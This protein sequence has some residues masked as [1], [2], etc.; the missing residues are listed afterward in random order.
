MKMRIETRSHDG[1]MWWGYVIAMT[2]WWAGLLLR[3]GTL[4]PPLNSTTC[5]PESSTQQDALARSPN[6][7]ISIHQV[8]TEQHLRTV[9]PLVWR[10]QSWFLYPGNVSLNCKQFACQQQSLLAPFPSPSVTLFHNLKVNFCGIC[11][12]YKTANDSNWHNNLNKHW[13]AFR[14]SE[15]DDQVFMLEHLSW[16]KGLKEIIDFS[17]YL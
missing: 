7:P 6:L 1:Y 17:A 8:L 11:T 2:N 3:I 10:I 16:M 5:V 13:D 9:G 4:R 14:M 15:S 12:M